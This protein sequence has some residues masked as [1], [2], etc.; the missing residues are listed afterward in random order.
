MIA[1]ATQQLLGPGIHYGIP[2]DV[3]H[4]WDACSNSRLSILAESC[5]AKLRWQIDHPAEQTAALVI[6]SALHC[7]ALEYGSFGDR[8][9]IAPP[10]NRTTKEGK[11]TWQVFIESVNGRKILRSDEAG[12][13]FGMASA[14]DKNV[15]A[16]R[17]LDLCPA[18]E[19]SAVWEDDSGLICKARL[20]VLSV[21]HGLIVDL[22]TTDNAGREFERS[23][24]TWGY[25]RQAAFYI[26][27]AA[28]LKIPVQDFV[29]I[30]VEKSPPYLIGIHRICERAIEAASKE[31]RPLIE[32]YWEA[33]AT[34]TWKGYEPRDADLPAWAHKR[35]ETTAALAAR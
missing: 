8:Y 35:I 24:D 34:G 27:G 18:R 32:A 1:E 16:R 12:A 33:Q 2:A 30:A 29:I 22:K 3:Y 19:V 5:P 4:A 31:L 23:I 28:K 7:L 13:A 14:I 10:C 15:H 20:D 21:E 17:L 11:A 9:S 26:A 6:G 25:A